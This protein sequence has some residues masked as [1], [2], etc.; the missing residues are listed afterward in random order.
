MIP[1]TEARIPKFWHPEHE[2]QVNNTHC[3]GSEYST[4]EMVQT[5]MLLI[6]SCHPCRLKPGP[7]AKY[8]VTV[9]NGL[10]WVLCRATVDLVPGGTLSRCKV[11][12][13]R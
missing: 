13:W 8:L 2:T 4:N 1:T 6:I 11:R 9:P 5:T 12:T 3:E 10:Q 7:G